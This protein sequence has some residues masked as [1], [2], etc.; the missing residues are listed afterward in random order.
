MAEQA[1][2]VSHA[3]LNGIYVK[4][5]ELDRGHNDADAPAYAPPGAVGGDAQSHASDANTHAS[6]HASDAAA[7]AS[8]AETHAS[9]LD[10]QT[11][12]SER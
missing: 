5:Q 12:A 10:V 2:K 3:S 11:H 7:H 9:N 8:D 1:D 4:A 6:T